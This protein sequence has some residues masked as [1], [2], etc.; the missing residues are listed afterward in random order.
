MA[1][2]NRVREL[3]QAGKPVINSWLGIPSSFSAEV[4]SH[5]GWD[6]L[7][8]DMQHGMIDYQ[9][10]VTM[11]QAISTTETVPLVR[12]PWNDPAHIQKALDAGA[13][14]I[15]CPMINNRAEAETFVSSM[16]YAPAGTR[17]SGPIRAAL[18]G[19]A[20]YHA[21]ANDIVVALGM[22]ETREAIA[23]LDEICSVK[24]LDAVYVGPSDLSISHGY[25]PGGD[26]PDDW[27]IAL[28]NKVLE[29][30]KRHGIVPGL[31]CGMPSYALKALD[32]GFRFVTV[33]GDTRFVTTG[34]AAAVAEMRGGAPKNP[35][36]AGSSSPY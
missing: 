13:Y 8:V 18:Y 12:V 1:R 15:I 11:L 14:G 19:G 7:V 28:L 4:M 27:M 30:C 2:P 24:G 21:K 34:A 9:M 35:A 32:M 31:H 16:R 29:A 23:N 5:A 25:P 26:K 36:R 17:S 10:M 3:W 6:S 20:D 22:I 33:G